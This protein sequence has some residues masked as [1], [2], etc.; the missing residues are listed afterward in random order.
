VTHDLEVGAGE[1]LTVKKGFRQK[2]PASAG[3]TD[4]ATVYGAGFSRLLVGLKHIAPCQSRGLLIAI[5]SPQGEF[6]EHEFS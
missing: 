4:P 5:R 2:P 1:S 3:G 6:L